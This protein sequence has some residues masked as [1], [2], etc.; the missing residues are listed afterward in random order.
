MCKTD[1]Q[2]DPLPVS[3]GCPYSNMH[4]VSTIVCAFS[5]VHVREC[6]CEC[7]CVHADYDAD[8]QASRICQSLLPCMHIQM[9]VAIVD[10]HLD[11]GNSRSSC[12]HST[13]WHTRPS[14][15]SLS[16]PFEPVASCVPIKPMAKI[17]QTFDHNA[18]VKPNL[19]PYF[20]SLRPYSIGET[21]DS[22]GE[23]IRKKSE[24]FP[25][26]YVCRKRSLALLRLCLAAPAVWSGKVRKCQRG[27]PAAVKGLS[28]FPLSH[29]YSGWFGSPERG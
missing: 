23:R 26:P 18:S 2:A 28:D 12:F 15:Q 8:K 16:S 11:A 13:R 14:L 25:K 5:P 10:F 27:G 21:W 29:S 17:K 24:F 1:R 3:W 20:P 6:V 9:S 22:W 19:A 7:V 4:S